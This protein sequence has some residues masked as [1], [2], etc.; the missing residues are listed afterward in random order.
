ML[1]HWAYLQPPFNHCGHSLNMGRLCAGAKC[2]SLVRPP[3]VALA[4]RQWRCCSTF[5]NSKRKED[6]EN[7]SL[8]STELWLHLQTMLEYKENKKF[9]PSCISYQRHLGYKHSLLSWTTYYCNF[10]WINHYSLKQELWSVK[11]KT[12]GGPSGSTDLI[13]QT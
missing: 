11:C 9:L 12:P 7:C 1:L 10:R 8:V 2:P 13:F 5:C 4:N 6:L 3:P